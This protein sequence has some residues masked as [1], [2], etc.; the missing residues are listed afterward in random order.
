MNNNKILFGTI[1]LLLVLIFTT[2]GTV[3]YNKYSNGFD[4]KSIVLNA[5]GNNMLNC[6]FAKETVGF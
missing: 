2:I 4:D 1:A 3:L 6:K 5:Q